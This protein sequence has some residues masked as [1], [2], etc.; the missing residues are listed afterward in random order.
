MKLLI[1]KAC[2]IEL[3]DSAELH[4]DQNG[5]WWWKDFF[6]IDG[7]VVENPIFSD[8]FLIYQD[9]KKPCASEKYNERINI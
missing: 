9:G 1:T 6:K 5:T 3:P 2:F 7:V 4:Q 8:Y